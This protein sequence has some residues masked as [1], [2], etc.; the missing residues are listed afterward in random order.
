MVSNRPMGVT[1]LAVL[2]LIVS[3]LLLIAGLQVFTTS[4]Q[5]G[6]GANVWREFGAAIAG[7]SAG[8]GWLYL[9]FGAIRLVLARGLFT[10]KVWAW[11]IT[12]ICEGISIANG[13]ASFGNLARLGIIM[14]EMLAGVIWEIVIPAI[15]IYY[16]LTPEV[17][18]AFGK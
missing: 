8:T 13:L 11:F 17:K 4:Y 15:I 7:P 12:L 2:Q 5:L 9:L 10:L 16:L 14:L 6:N 18:R 3:I 1:I